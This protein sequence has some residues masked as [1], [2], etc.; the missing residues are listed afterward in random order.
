MG[1]IQL[2]LAVPVGFVIV[3]LVHDFFAGLSEERLWSDP[4][5][6][7]PESFVNRAAAAERRVSAVTSINV[8]AGIDPL[9]KVAA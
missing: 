1:W 3:A 9:P 6:E 5:L 8:Q 7:D 4:Y 2:L